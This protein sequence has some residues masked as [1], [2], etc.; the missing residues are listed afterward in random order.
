MNVKACWAC[1]TQGWKS[2]VEQVIATHAAEQKSYELT[3]YLLI[4]RL[5]FRY[6]LYLFYDHRLTYSYAPPFCIHL[7]RFLILRLIVKGI[8]LAFSTAEWIF[9]DFFTTNLS[10]TL[11]KYYFYFFFYFCHAF[12]LLKLSWI[13]TI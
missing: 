7:F 11:L 6:F 9:C 3:H 8:Y 2:A 13:V 5:F 10:Q 1:I 12:I 4:K